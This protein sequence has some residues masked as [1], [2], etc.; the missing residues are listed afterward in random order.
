MKTKKKRF[1]LNKLFYGNFK[2]SL[3]YLKKIKNYVWFSLILFLLFGIFGFLFPSFFEKQILKLLAELIGETQGLGSLELIRFIFINNLK[4]SF[5]A[6]IFGIFLG[7]MPLII[8]VMNGYVLGF[9]INKSVLLEGVF[10]LWRLLPHGI[11]EIPAVMIS[12]GLGLKLGISWIYDCITFNRKISKFK[13]YLFILLSIL[14][15]PISFIVLFVLTLMNK[16]LKSKFFNNFKNV[17]RAFIFVVIPLLIVAGIIEG[18][19]ISFLS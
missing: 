7:I 11:F 10:V 19:L 3:D 14:L 13:I 18:F 8:C 17:F 5:F 16:E 6:M 1:N 15:F 12:I 9:V 2:L 4:S